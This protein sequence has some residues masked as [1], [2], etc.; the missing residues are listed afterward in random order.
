[1][2]VF[3][4]TLCTQ[5]NSRLKSVCSIP[6][7]AL[8]PTAVKDHD[9]HFPMSTL[10]VFRETAGLKKISQLEITLERAQEIIRDVSWSHN[11]TETAATLVSLLP[12]ATYVTQPKKVNANTA[13]VYPKQPP[14]TTHWGIV[15]G[16]PTK[17]KTAYLFHLVLRE[18]NGKR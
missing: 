13:Y 10:D 7:L 15:V 3:R 18:R 17:R 9:S 2:R 1:M 8:L 4:T 5:F 16:D 14:F 11:P 6:C 12:V